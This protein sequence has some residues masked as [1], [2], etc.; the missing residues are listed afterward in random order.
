MVVW[1]KRLS[2]CPD[3]DCD[4]N[5]SSETGSPHRLPGVAD[6]AGPGRGL[7]A[8]GTG[9]PRRGPG[10]PLP[11]RRVVERDGGCAR[12]CPAPRRRLRP[13]LRPGGL[14]LGRD[15]LLAASSFPGQRAIS[16]TYGAQLRRLLKRRVKG[17]IVGRFSPTSSWVSSRRDDERMLNGSGH[18]N[19]LKVA[20]AEDGLVRFHVALVNARAGRVDI[21]AVGECWRRGRRSA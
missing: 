3:A 15:G 21:E 8:G 6:R 4:V 5:T 14:G 16:Q 2:R 7:P 11:G 20:Q 10:W 1:V 19:G 13:H 18:S 9:Q 12:L 17:S